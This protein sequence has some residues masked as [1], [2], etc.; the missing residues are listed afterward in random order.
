MQE[1]VVQYA[2]AE[3]VPTAL[4]YSVARHESGFNPAARGRAGEWGVMQI[5]C[6]TAR[7]IGYKGSCSGLADAETNVKWGMRYLAGAHKLAGGSQC[8]TLS[9]Y[10]GGHG[11]TRLIRG[12]CNSVMR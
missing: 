7:G 12:Y 5:K 11:T 3:G 4:A 2:Q 8:G 1:L 6:G 10:N 9:R